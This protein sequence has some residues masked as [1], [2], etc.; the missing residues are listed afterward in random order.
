[1]TAYEDINA[2]IN[3][4]FFLSGRSG[5]QPVY[6]DIEDEVRG[7]LS[8]RLSV[9][10]GN[11]DAVIGKAVAQTLVN[12]H[13]DG[14]GPYVLAHPQAPRLA[15]SRTTRCSPLHGFPLRAIHRGGAN[16]ERQ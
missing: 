2:A 10:P 3:E 5:N 6:L 7:V 8:D 4:V 11:I 14:G 15:G 16:A 12:G 1:M 9:E 13:R